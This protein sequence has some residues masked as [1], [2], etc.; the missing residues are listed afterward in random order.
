MSH[1]STPNGCK[2]R[3]PA[4]RNENKLRSVRAVVSKQIAKLE[5]IDFA[6]TENQL[7]TDNIHA[8]QAYLENVLIELE[9]ALRG[10]S[11]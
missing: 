10:D 11:I 4:C 2:A 1:W 5:S 3:C 6:N 8:A 9:A 7:Q